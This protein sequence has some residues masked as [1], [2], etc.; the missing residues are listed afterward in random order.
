MK[1]IEN[2]Q[3]LEVL[4]EAFYNALLADAT[5]SYIFTDVAKIN[6][7]SHLPHII[8]FWEQ[9]LFYTGNYRKNVMQIH[10]DLNSKE[11]LT[12]VHFKTWL[13]H[14]YATADS[15][16]VGDNVEKLKTRAESIATIM[17]IKIY[18]N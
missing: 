9:S 1:D 2:R 13:H 4:L 11:H 15:L 8:D 16:F 7:Q 18:Q 14:L 6:L 12:D 10:L 3:D 5:I 17:K